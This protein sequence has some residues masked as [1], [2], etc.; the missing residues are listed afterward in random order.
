V[1]RSGS[2]V[3]DQTVQVFGGDRLA[4]FADGAA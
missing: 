3:L 4:I 1:H 2:D